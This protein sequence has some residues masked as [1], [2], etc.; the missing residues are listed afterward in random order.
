M[1]HVRTPEYQDP[2]EDGYTLVFVEVIHRH[3]KRTPFKSN[4]FFQEDVPWDCSDIHISAI[5]RSSTTRLDSST[6]IS[7]LTTGNYV[8][9]FARSVGPGFINSNCQFPQ[10]TAQG[11]VDAHVHGCDL[12]SI[13]RDKLGFLPD[14]VS[15]PEVAFR[16]TNNAITSQTLG[17]LLPGLFSDSKGS[18]VNAIVEPSSHDPLEPTIECPL[19]TTIRKAYTGTH[20][21]WLEHLRASVNMFMRLDSV[22]GISN[23]DTAGWHSSFD[24]YYDN[25]SA[26]QCHQKSLPCSVND[27]TICV[28]QE[29]ANMVYRLGNYGE[30][31]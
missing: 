31:R 30:Y 7:W 3:H 17:A 1:P 9:P 25:F 28:R 21:V 13:Y 16:V 11:L 23:P 12:A 26:K 22:S 2:T 20:P 19:A 14:S 10:L 18:Q 24:H 4:V 29:D 8:N 15:S 27:T 6:E 5:S